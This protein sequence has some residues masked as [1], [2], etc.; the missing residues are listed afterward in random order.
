MIALKYKGKGRNE[1]DEFNIS[2]FTLLAA[3]NSACFNAD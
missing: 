1:S 2:K 3:Y